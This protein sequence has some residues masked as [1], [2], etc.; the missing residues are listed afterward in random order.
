MTSFPVLSGGDVGQRSVD[1]DG[2]DVETLQCFTQGHSVVKRR[3]LPDAPLR[4]HSFSRLTPLIQAIDE[5][6][7]GRDDWAQLLC[8]GLVGV[9]Q[10]IIIAQITSDVLHT[11]HCAEVR[12]SVGRAGR[13][14]ADGRLADGGCV[15]VRSHLSFQISAVKTSKQVLLLHL[16][17]LLH[18]VCERAEQR[19]GGRTAHTL[20]RVWRRN[21]RTQSQSQSHANHKTLF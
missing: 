10:Q 19:S 13:V 4:K 7:V 18:D 9:Q 5:L 15:C 6:C 8:A 16:S 2:A 17:L 14:S 21:W 20:L 11:L 3:A 12:A 1:G